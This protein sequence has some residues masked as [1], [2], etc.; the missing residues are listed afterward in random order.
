MTVS[1]FQKT[2]PTIA[3]S[4]ERMGKVYESPETLLADTFAHKP[5]E[6]ALLDPS[7]QVR[8]TTNPTLDR[9]ELL[10]GSLGL[11][12]MVGAG[13][14]VFGGLTTVVLGGAG[15][16]LK[17]VFPILQMGSQTTA[18]GALGFVAKGSA[19]VGL[20]AG[21]FLYCA[22]EFHDR[23]PLARNGFLYAT[24]NSPEQIAI[25]NAAGKAFADIETFNITK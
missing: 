5:Y 18:A 7:L 10:K 14:L 13:A 15:E 1:G 6:E 4:Y 20:A 11:A 12:L 9:V 16:V 23:K 17:Q 19:A 21:T 24:G 8:V 2:A 22:E 3:R 25:G